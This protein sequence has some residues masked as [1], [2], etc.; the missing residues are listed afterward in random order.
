MKLYHYTSIDALAMILKN[1]T[2]RFNRLDKV[3]DI[4]EASMFEDTI[5]M[6]KYVFVSCWTNDAEESIPLWKMYTPSMKGVRISLDIDMF[7]VK[8]TSIGD[9][10]TAL[11]V[12]SV[13][14]DIQ[15]YF[16]PQEQYT[17]H[18]FIAHL[19]E[20]QTSFFQEVNY[21]D[22]LTN[23]GKKAVCRESNESEFRTNVNSHK[24]GTYKHKR[25]AFQK[26]CR[27]VLTILPVA[28]GSDPVPCRIDAAMCNG[29]ELPFSF[30]DMHL[31][32][33]V[34]QDMEITLSP[35]ST[36]SDQI[37]VES[38][39]WSLNPSAKVEKSH[40]QGLIRR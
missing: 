25:W 17:P 21:V 22:D 3:D 7:D 40:L 28:P 4:E 27:F 9:Y 10:P 30:Y 6:G 39:V 23:I 13:A 36:I 37:I 34:L 2:I 26:E 16:S 14:E 29:Q 18:Y 12:V 11:G 31:S 38:L 1:R 35:C 24:V 5:P 15:T 33:K 8:M 32:A 20:K 19:G